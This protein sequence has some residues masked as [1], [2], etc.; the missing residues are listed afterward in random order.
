MDVI[1]LRSGIFT[2]RTTVK[3]STSSPHHRQFLLNKI[4]EV[5]WRSKKK[6]KKVAALPGNRFPIIQHK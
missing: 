4:S 1:T 3:L 6:E 2:T 5:R